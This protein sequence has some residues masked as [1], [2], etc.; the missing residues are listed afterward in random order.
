MK[1]LL[2]EDEERIAHFLLRGLREEGHLLVWERDGLAGYD[3]ALGQSFDAIILDLMLPGMNGREICQKLREAG[4]RSKILMLTAM[5]TTADL[6]KGFGLGADDYLT[7]PFAFDELTARL[8]ALARRGEMAPPRQP[9]AL[10]A[11]DLHFD[12]EALIVTL[13]GTQLLMTSLEYALLEFLM[14]EKGK[15]LSR[16]R[17]LQHVWGAS[18]DPLTNVVDVY[19][20]RLRRHF[21]PLGAADRIVTIRGRGYRL[22]D[23]AP[24]PNAPEA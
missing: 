8:Q 9:R 12:T 19:I 16:S 5:A 7:K 18:E 15:V 23:P 21:A 13:N 3:A 22:H 2:I 24:N 6:V 11:G 10:Q 1:L 17:I 20:K 4:V 14:Q